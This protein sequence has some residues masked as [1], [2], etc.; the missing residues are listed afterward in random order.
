MSDF[1]EASFKNLWWEKITAETQGLFRTQILECLDAETSSNVR[2]LIADAI[3][4]IGASLV[5]PLD[6]KYQNA[7][8]ELID[9][10]WKFF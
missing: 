3:G 4:E 2:G 5:K 1:S 6:S 7:W 9:L 10:L 8:P